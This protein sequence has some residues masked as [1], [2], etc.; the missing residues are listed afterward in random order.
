[1]SGLD[2]QPSGADTY[3][4][5]VD[6][7]RALRKVLRDVLV[8]LFIT[9]DEQLDARIV[10]MADRVAG[11]RADQEQLDATVRVF[12]E[13]LAA[14]VD[15]VRASVAQLARFAGLIEALVTGQADI[16]ARIEHIEQHTFYGPYTREQLHEMFQRHE[17]A[18]DEVEALTVRV[19]ALEAWRAATTGGGGGDG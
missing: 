19:S 4:L 15:D 5:A 6:L 12:E 13:R 3:T 17:R 1:M 2:S 10:A 7:E 8:P 9:R 14:A 11:A 16:L 18:A